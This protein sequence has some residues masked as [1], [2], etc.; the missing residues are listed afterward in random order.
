[1]STLHISFFPGFY[2]NMDRSDISAVTPSQTT[3]NTDHDPKKGKEKTSFHLE[4]V[5]TAAS[6][7]DV[8][9]DSSDDWP[10]WKKDAQIILVAFHSTISTA[11]GIVPGFDIFAEQ[12]G[13]TV[14]TTSYLTSVQVCQI[15]VPM[16]SSILDTGAMLSS[17]NTSYWARYSTMTCLE[18]PENPNHQR[19]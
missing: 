9:D 16:L 5:P 11:A 12:Y 18:N 10:K 7:L 1:M 8:V 3:L 15:L 17:P 14:Q 6:T 4:N 2:A 13:V 19:R